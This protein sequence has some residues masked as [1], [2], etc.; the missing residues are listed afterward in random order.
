MLVEVPPRPPPAAPMTPGG[1]SRRTDVTLRPMGLLPLLLVLAATVAA[2]AQSPPTVE[3]PTYASGQRWVRSDGVYELV[4]IEDGL[5]VFATGAA[6]G[7]PPHEGPRHRPHAERSALQRDRPADPAEVAAQGRRVGPAELIWR[8]TDN[9]TGVP[10]RF[11][12]RGRRLRG[13]EGPGRDVQGVPDR[14]ARRAVGTRG[15]RPSRVVRARPC[16]STSRAAR[17]HAL[18]RRLQRRLGRRAG[19]AADRARGAAPSPRGST[20]PRC[21]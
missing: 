16:G 15:T 13:R 1:T 7:S 8:W 4:R 17:R 3:R 14:H 20:P 5:Y 2:D 6:P 11:V 12:W 18:A 9:P 10:A 21:G 19:A